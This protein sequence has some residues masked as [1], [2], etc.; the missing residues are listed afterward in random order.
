MLDIVSDINMVGGVNNVANI[1][2]ELCET[3]KPNFKKLILLSK[4]YKTSSI[5]RLGF[6][7]E[8]FTDVPVPDQFKIISDK[9]KVSTSLLDP[10]STITGPIDKKW[11]LRINREVEPDI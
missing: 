11:N 2:I 3:S 10:K 1:I 6:L 5:R 4:F 8:H 9:R 7:I